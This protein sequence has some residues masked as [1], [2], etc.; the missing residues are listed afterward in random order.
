MMTPYP[1]YKAPRLDPHKALLLNML[2]SRGNAWHTPFGQGTARW[3][4]LAAAPSFAPAC[5][6]EFTLGAYAWTAYFSDAS[7][8]LRHEAFGSA[9][10]FALEE[11]PAEV[12]SAVLHSLLSQSAGAFQQAAGE[13]ISLKGI[14]FAPAAYPAERALGAKLWLCG[15]P[16]A[17]M[18]LLAAFVPHE[19]QAAS[20]AAELLKHL[21]FRPN[22]A[23]AGAV[24]AL[25]LEVA[26]E[27]GYLYL[28]SAEAASLEAEDVLLPAAWPLAEGRLDMRVYRG[29]GSVLAGV[30]AVANNQAVLEGPLAE[31]MDSDM[32]SNEQKDIEI[33]LSFELDR[34]VITVGELAALTPG[35]TFPLAGD[36]DS[37]VTVRAQGKPFARGR[38]V[39]MNGVLGVQLT[40]LL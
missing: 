25:P 6:V 3:E 23:L 34:R 17:D 22:P 18:G 38:I 36:M 7:F 11:L 2:F 21:P 31:E 19:P 27:T 30:C 28:T 13:M 35:F 15:G 26:L 29:A 33:R 24:A 10:G 4:F 14:D 40:E 1:L 16:C 39:D 32:E 8:L 9:G 5:A 20:A 37:A 12:R